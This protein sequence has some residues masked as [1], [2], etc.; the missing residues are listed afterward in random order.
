LLPH[1]QLREIV[2]PNVI[3][4]L[5]HHIGHRL[6][7]RGHGALVSAVTAAGGPLHGNYSA[8]KAYVLNLDEA[9]HVELR[10]A[11]VNVT[12]LVPLLVPLAEVL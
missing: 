3:T 10:Q 5:E 2:H 8:T 9:L 4:H 6:A 12:D 7:E 11:G 1:E